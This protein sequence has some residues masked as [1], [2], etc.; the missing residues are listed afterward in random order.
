MDCS[1]V[2]RKVIR[3]CVS[4]HDCFYHERFLIQNRFFLFSEQVED[5]QKTHGYFL[6]M[7]GFTLVGP[8]GSS[9]HP[10]TLDEFLDLL[11]SSKIAFPEIT[12]A[13]IKDNARGDFLSKVIAILQNHLVHCTMC[14]SRSRD[15]RA[16]TCQP[17]M[18]SCTF[19]GGTNRWVSISQ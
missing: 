4:I 3:G 11:R 16:R 17:L 19:F 2:Y 7:G 5:G 9:S 6:I 14:R 12:D 1:E 13:E 15:N 18:G 10:L 8:D